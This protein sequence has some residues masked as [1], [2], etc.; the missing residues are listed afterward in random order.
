ME[1]E[2]EVSVCMETEYPWEE[3][4]KLSVS[5]RRKDNWEIA[6]RIPGWCRGYSLTVD[7]K[8]VK[9]EMKDGYAYLKQCWEGE[10]IIEL[11]LEMPAHT[12]RACPKVRDTIGK[13]TV[14]RG[15]VVYCLE[16]E[17]N[18]KELH[19]VEMAADT[20][21]ETEY[22]KDELGGIVAVHA[23]GR[24]VI[25]PE[26]ES[27]YSDDMDIKYEEK[28]LLWIPYY[29]WA[30]RHAGEMAVWIRQSI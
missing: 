17:D 13:L 16:E 12:M 7:G 30:N 21:L 9:Y 10:H 14:M 24:K 22:L 29:A 28:E 19:A 20:K 1:G 25:C 23:R 27:L 3:T 5:C 15:P 2:K 11:K 8:A 18:G 26:Q 6:V 4:V